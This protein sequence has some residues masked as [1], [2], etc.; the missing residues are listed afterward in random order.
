MEFRGNESTA[1]AETIDTP[2]M[3]TLERKKLALASKDGCQKE[4]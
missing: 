3:I 4:A 2:I 1:M